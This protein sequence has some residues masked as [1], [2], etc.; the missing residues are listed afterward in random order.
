[1]TKDTF[2][3]VLIALRYRIDEAIDGVNTK[4]RQ[5]DVSELEGEECIHVHTTDEPDTYCAHVKV[6]LK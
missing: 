5:V 4:G 3:I 2:L 6:K 1:M